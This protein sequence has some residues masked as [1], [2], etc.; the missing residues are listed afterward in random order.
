MKKALEKEKLDVE[1]SRTSFPQSQKV[2]VIWKR[3]EAAEMERDG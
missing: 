1:K 2:I 3:M